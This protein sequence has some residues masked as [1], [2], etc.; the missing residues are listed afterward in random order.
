M[1]IPRVIP[2]LLLRRRGLVKTVRF[3]RARYIGDPLNAVKI[4]NEKGADELVALDITAWPERRGPDYDFL[5]QLAGECFM[6]LCYGGG[7]RTLDQMAALYR[8][9]IEKVILGA[10]AT[11]PAFIS[12]A[13]A[14]FG[15]QSVAVCIDVRRNWLGGRSVRV[16]NGRRLA[17]RDPIAYARAAAA[18]G[19]G[20]LILQSID[21][22]GTGQGYALD[23][24]R[25][26]SAA[27]DVPVVALGGA[28]SH[29]D[30]RA[31]L[32][33]GAAAAAAGSQFVYYGPHRAVLI[34]YPSP[35]ELAAIAAG[36]A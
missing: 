34:S 17:G 32:Q 22:E 27:V 4:F 11:Q 16:E 6:P 24:V 21:H 31:A 14:R 19:A 35:D 26:V 20:E 29:D 7:V 1:L 33:A 23:L 8:L 12:A 9:G 36:A 25:A 10:A 28:A 30:L 5:A 18:A 15:S 3:R 2:C 13:A